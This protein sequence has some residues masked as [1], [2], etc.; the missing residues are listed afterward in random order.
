MKMNL[1]KLT[2]IQ[3]TLYE[4]IEENNFYDLQKSIRDDL[5]N[6]TTA[7]Y[8]DIEL[9]TRYIMLSIKLDL[10]DRSKEDK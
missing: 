10:E 7:S 4:W 6:T 9:V 8:A 2:F 1:N 3:T 5:V